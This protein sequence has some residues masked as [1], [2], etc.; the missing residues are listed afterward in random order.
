[1]ADADRGPLPLHCPHCGAP[2]VRATHDAARYRCRR[3]PQNFHM[4][5]GRL[6]EDRAPRAL[7]SIRGGDPFETLQLRRRVNAAID[8]AP[9]PPPGLLAPSPDLVALVCAF[10]E[11]F[12][13]IRDELERYSC[14]ERYESFVCQ[15]RRHFPVGFPHRVARAQGQR[16]LGEIADL[17]GD[18]DA[19]I[20]H[21]TQALK[22]FNTVGCRT[23]LAALVTR[24]R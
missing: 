3:C 21:Y 18:I 19:A 6:I 9:F 11:A 7:P 22:S 24:T 1:M 8:E 23:K 5:D 17:R 14:R 15:L 12:N 2:L 4:E 16:R 20:W 10:V 13:E